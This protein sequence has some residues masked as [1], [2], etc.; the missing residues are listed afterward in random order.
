MGDAELERL[1]GSSAND[2]RLARLLGDPALAWL[3]ARVRRRIELGQPLDGAVTL[4]D[5]SSA[6]RR[7]AQRLLGRPPRAGRALS[8]P[9]RAVDEVL[10]SS[11][12]CAEGLE[13]AVVAITGPVLV[14]ADALTAE[15]HAWEQTFAPLTGLVS[16]LVQAGAPGGERLAVWLERLRGSGS[17]KRTQPDPE[18]ARALLERLAA[19]LEA[20]PAD[21]QPLAGFAARVAG[22]AH[23][24]DDGRP[25][26]ALALGAVRAFSGLAGPGPGESYAEARR[27]AW[28]SV[29]L[30]CDDL[31]STVLALGLPGEQHTAS[32][33]ILQAAQEGGQ[34]VWLTLRQ[35]V[36]DMPSWA[37]ATRKGLSG[38]TVYI[39]ENP[40]VVAVAADRLGQECAPLVCTSGQPGAATMLLLGALGAAGARLVHHGDFDWGGIRIGNVLHRRL[41]LEAWQFDTEA[42]MRAADAVASHQPLVGAAVHA[43]WDPRLSETMRHAERRIEEELVL[44][45][46]LADLAA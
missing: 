8:V 5:A 24:L 18:V 38:Q 44:N 7:A 28:A 14:R 3:L 43:S 15:R 40:V 33:R 6:Q 9:L 45:R 20:L 16:G 34:P 4:A 2:E 13:A 10:R 26:A 12:A 27:E 19:V 36:R 1:N 35:L 41:P 23:A 30:L 31:S 42:Y 22:G 29:G 39:C 17:V 25:L 21:G 11:G 37:G 32:G 46:L